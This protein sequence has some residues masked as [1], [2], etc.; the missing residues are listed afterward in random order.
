[1]VRD[2]GNMNHRKV[3]NLPV[4]KVSFV[5]IE[6]A[7]EL[8]ELAE[9]G[10]AGDGALVGVPAAAGELGLIAVKHR[11]FVPTRHGV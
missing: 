7:D 2:Q 3:A 4:G 8:L 1:M 11:S 6:A 5:A 9:G 10:V